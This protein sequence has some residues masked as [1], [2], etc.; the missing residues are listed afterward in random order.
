MGA[1]K[2]GTMGDAWDVLC[3]ALPQDWRKLA[4]ETG[5]SRGLRKDPSVDNLLRTPPAA[6]RLRTLVARDGAS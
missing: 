2:V 3:L 6:S 4:Q 5:A 1:Y